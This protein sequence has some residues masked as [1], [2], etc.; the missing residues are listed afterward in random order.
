[1]IPVW[2]KHW[3]RGP[4]HGVGT[5]QGTQSRESLGEMTLKGLFLTPQISNHRAA[6][7]G[8][9]SPSPFM[10]GDRRNRSTPSGAVWNVI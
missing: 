5:G 8:G 3:G 2:V 1:M 9:H 7:R 10:A 4:R 6:Q